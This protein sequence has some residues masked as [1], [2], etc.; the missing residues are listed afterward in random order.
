VLSVWAAAAVPM[1]VLAWVVAPAIAGQHATRERFF[2]A[3]LSALTFGL[4][5]PAVLVLILV[6]RESEGHPSWAGL[7]DLLWLRAPQTATRR[8]GRLWRWVPVFALALAALDMAAVGPSGPESRSFGLFLNSD[9]GRQAFH[10]SWA[11]Y[12]LVAIELALTPS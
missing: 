2:V 10:H 8:G 7:R 6:S 1:A 5:W 11:L 4:L 3:L 9:A 12:A